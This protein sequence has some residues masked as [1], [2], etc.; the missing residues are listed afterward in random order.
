MAHKIADVALLLNPY[1][2]CLLFVFA[3]QSYNTNLLFFQPISPLLVC[4][5]IQPKLKKLRSST[6]NQ[7]FLMASEGFLKFTQYSLNIS[8]LTRQIYLLNIFLV[9]ISPRTPSLISD[10]A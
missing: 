3:V 7:S 2:F 5:N 1:L 9:E 6:K 10:I 8:T 4:A